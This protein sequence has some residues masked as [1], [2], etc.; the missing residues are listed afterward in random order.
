M[1]FLC[2]KNV[3][4]DYKVF[5]DGHQVDLSF[6]GTNAKYQ[7]ELSK[8]VHLLRIKKESKKIELGKIFAVWLAALVGSYDENNIS[9]Y[10]ASK[11]IDIT[12]SFNIEESDC[13]CVFEAN[14]NKLICTT[15]HSLELKNIEE[16]N[17]TKRK[18]FLLLKLP[19]AILAFSVLIPLWFMSLLS[20]VRSFE[21]APFL[22]LILLTGLIML[23]IFA[24][25]QNKNNK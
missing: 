2:L 9:V 25:F 20:I 6:S 24:F 8:G 5:I 22:L 11:S 10:R 18:I 19:F 17:A 14:E 15:E 3:C 13:K 21:P 7:E 4:R 1:F 16:N 12:Y 23:F